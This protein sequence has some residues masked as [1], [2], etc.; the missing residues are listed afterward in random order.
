MNPMADDIDAFPVG[1]LLKNTSKLG[2]YS[3]PYTEVKSTR[4]RQNWSLS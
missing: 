1:H 2:K 3:K 4:K